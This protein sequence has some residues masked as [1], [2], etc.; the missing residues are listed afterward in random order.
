MLHRI[1]NIHCKLIP[2]VA[3]VFAGAPHQLLVQTILKGEPLPEGA[4]TLKTMVV[5]NNLSVG[6]NNN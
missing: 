5:T 1:T 2:L 4:A 6:A 3:R